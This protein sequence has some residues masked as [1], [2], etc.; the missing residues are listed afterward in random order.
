VTEVG[1]KDYTTNITCTTSVINDGSGEYDK[2][3]VTVNGQKIYDASNGNGH[4]T[5]IVVGE[6]VIVFENIKDYNADTGVRLDVIP[7]IV[8]FIIAIAGVVVFLAT[9]KKRENR[10]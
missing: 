9:R 10:F 7:Y 5:P 8:V 4:G 2:N 1:G 6:N 3:V